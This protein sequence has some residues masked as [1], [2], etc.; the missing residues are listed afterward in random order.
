MEARDQLRQEQNI[1]TAYLRIAR[2]AVQ[3]RMCAIS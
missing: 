2:S 3:R 1:P